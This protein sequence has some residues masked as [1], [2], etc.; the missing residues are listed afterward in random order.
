MFDL[1]RS[2]QKA[3]RYLLGGLLALVALSMVI[4]LIPGFGSN[5]RAATDETVLAEIGSEKVMAQD[6]AR[7]AQRVLSGNKIPPDMIETYLPMFIESMIQQKAVL[8]EFERQGLGATDEEVRSNLYATYPG[9]FK[10]GQLVDK[11][12]VEAVLAQE[13]QTL[14]DIVDDSRRDVILKTRIENIIFANVVVS[15]K[16]VDEELGRRFDKAKIK[17]VAFPPAKFKDQAKATNEQVMAYFN[18]H[19][20]Q[21]M[22]PEKRSFQ[23]I[24]IDQDKVEAGL[25]ISDAQLRAV[26]AG[27]MDNFRIPERVKIRHIMVK[28]VDKSDA[29]KKQLQAKAEGLVKQLRG[30]ADFADLAKKNSDDTESAAKGGEMDWI[31]RGQAVPEAEKAIFAA[32]PKEIT[33]VVATPYGFEIFQLLEHEQARVKP[34]DE[35]KVALAAELKKQG[36]AEKLQQISEQARAELTKSPGSA[37][38]IAKKLGVEVVTVTKATPGEA[39]PTLGVSPE[40]DS[41]LAGLPV[42]GVSAVLTLPANRLAVAVLNDRVP[43]AQSEFAEVEKKVRDQVLSDNALVLAGEKAK[44]FAEKTIK[45]GEDLEKLAKAWKLDVVESTEFTHNDSVEGLGQAVYVSDAFTKPAGTVLGPV[46]V[47]GRNVVY[48]VVDH[49]SVDPSKLTKE[50]QAIIDDLKRQKGA[51]LF[52]LFEDSVVTKLVAE[53]KV[54][55]HRDAIRKLTSTFHQ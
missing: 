15:P 1:F 20:T 35:V 28:T 16:E 41:A 36:I 50:R 27:S 38:E 8:Y 37:P 32:K 22:N 24:V 18:N 9:F 21:Y 43:A 42:K 19:R 55:I 10:D 39:I 25:N 31:V 17:Y 45:G 34:F 12:Q 47:S 6:A 2:R 30:G 46:M 44:E 29:E 23:V 4:T 52:A 5:S 48:K 7:Q 54:K 14:Q 49:T 51:T 3:V 13:G 11:A 33:D 53:G 26:Y 40:I